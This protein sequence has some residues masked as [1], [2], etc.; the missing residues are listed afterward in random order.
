MVTVLYVHPATNK[1]TRRH[2]ALQTVVVTGVAG[3]VPFGEEQDANYNGQ[4]KEDHH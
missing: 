4:D 3:A 1:H 2:N